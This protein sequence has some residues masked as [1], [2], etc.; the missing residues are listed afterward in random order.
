MVRLSSM[1][2]IFVLQGRS[3][4]WTV[5]FYGRLEV[6]LTLIE[7]GANVNLTDKVGVPVGLV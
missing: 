7:A 1:F 3:P 2:M 6:V 4:L 5:I